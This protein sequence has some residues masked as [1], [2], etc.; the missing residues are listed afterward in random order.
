MLRNF[1]LSWWEGQVAF[2]PTL[3]HSIWLLSSCLHP[4][5]YRNHD[6][7]KL[8]SSSG[9]DQYG[10]NTGHTWRDS[11]HHPLSGRYSLSVMIRWHGWYVRRETCTDMHCIWQGRKNCDVVPGGGLLGVLNYI[12]TG[13]LSVFYVLSTSITTSLLLEYYLTLSRLTDACANAQ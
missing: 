5:Q 13:I 10:T 1:E 4:H 11:L 12:Y 2:N 3:L 7:L 6:P 9:A 8:A